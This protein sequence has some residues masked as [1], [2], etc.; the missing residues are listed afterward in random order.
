VSH[1]GLPVLTVCQVLVELVVRPR[2]EKNKQGAVIGEFNETQWTYEWIPTTRNSPSSSEYR[3]NSVSESDSGDYSC[4]LR[5][6]S[7]LH[8][9]K[10]N[11]FIKMYFSFHVY[12]MYYV[13][14]YSI[15]T[16]FFT[17]QFCDHYTFVIYNK[18]PD[19]Q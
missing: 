4:M 13:L 8:L 7:H 17:F 5:K 11:C 2:T 15:I 1:E 10:E 19:R 12:C 18:S 14:F 3:I 16:I 6:T 9:L